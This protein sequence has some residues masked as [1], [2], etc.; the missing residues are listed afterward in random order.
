[1]LPNKSH[2]KLAPHENERGNAFIIILVAVVLFVGLA[3]TITRGLQSQTTSALSGQEL[4]LAVS[5]ILAFSQR[6]ERAVDRVRNKGCSE[7]EISFD[8]DVVAGYHHTSPPADKCQIFGKDGGGLVWQNPP[9]GANDGTPWVFSGHNKVVGIGEDSGNELL[10]IL[11]NM[12]K[13]VC[14]AINENLNVTASVMPPRD[15]NASNIT[16]KYRGTFDPAAPYLGNAGGGTAEFTGFSAACYEGGTTPAG[17][18]YHFYKTI[19]VR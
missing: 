3:F 7:N 4:K 9:E 19:L 13:A 8:N 10:I 12:D 18:T 16:L 17:G 6:V 5:D 2:H 14:D 1:M 11:P 15:G